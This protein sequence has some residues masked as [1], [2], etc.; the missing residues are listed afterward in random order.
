MK[1]GEE[2]WDGGDEL[3]LRRLEMEDGPLGNSA[4][5]IGVGHVRGSASVE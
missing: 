3:L 4:A 1:D 5:M 2:R